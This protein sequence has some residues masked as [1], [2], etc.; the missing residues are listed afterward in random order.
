MF[1]MNSYNFNLTPNQLAVALAQLF[2]AYYKNNSWDTDTAE[3]Y[4]YTLVE[5]SPA[6]IVFAE[7]EKKQGFQAAKNLYEVIRIFKSLVGP[8]KVL[9]NSMDFRDWWEQNPCLLHRAHVQVLAGADDLMPPPEPTEH[10]AIHK[11]TGLPYRTDV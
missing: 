2:H 9:V 10:W 8:C 7:Y 6:S 4:A 11:E 5:A 1:V 3:I